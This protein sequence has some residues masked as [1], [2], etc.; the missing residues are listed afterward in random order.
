[1]KESQI[2]EVTLNNYPENENLII[3]IDK[4][5]QGALSLKKNSL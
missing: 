4:S 5:N 2:G 3:S 1:M